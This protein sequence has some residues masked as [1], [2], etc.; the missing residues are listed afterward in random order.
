MN[1]TFVL[2]FWIILKKIL[3]IGHSLLLSH[4]YGLRIRVRLEYYNRKPS[5]NTSPQS[6]TGGLQ[7]PKLL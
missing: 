5:K 1:R 3:K 6:A 2:E 7:Q 4:K